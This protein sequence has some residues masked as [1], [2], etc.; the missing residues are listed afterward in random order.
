M[1]T[2]C[3]IPYM[4]ES[5]LSTATRFTVHTESNREQQSLAGTWHFSS[6]MRYREGAEDLKL[7]RVELHFHNLNLRESQV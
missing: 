1:E 6:G 5:I 2:C 3:R 4:P 7:T